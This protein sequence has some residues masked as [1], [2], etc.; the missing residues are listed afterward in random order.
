MTRRTHHSDPASHPG[1]I[2]GDGMGVG[3]GHRSPCYNLTYKTPKNLINDSLSLNKVT[4][5]KTHLRLETQCI[6]SPRLSPPP[7]PFPVAPDI[8]IHS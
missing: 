8:S 1:V 4:K 5:Q 2:I 6:S 7:S 3:F